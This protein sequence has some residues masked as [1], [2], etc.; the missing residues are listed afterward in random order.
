MRRI[1]GSG[2]PTVY[3]PTQV[4]QLTDDVPRVELKAANMRQ[5]VDG[6]EELFPGIKARLCTGDELSPS[7]Q[8]SIDGVMSN[9]GLSAKVKPSSEVHFIPAIGGG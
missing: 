3:I 6:L 7:L 2:L 4:R 5:V 8:V 9:R 1:R